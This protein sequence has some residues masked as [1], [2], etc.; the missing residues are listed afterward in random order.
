M[1]DRAG[2]YR[3][4]NGSAVSAAGRVLGLLVFVLA[5]GASAALVHSHVAARSVEAVAIVS[6]DAQL[7]AIYAAVD[8][9]SLDEALRLT[10]KLIA[11]QPNFRLA[12]LI[13]GD[14]LLAHV[15][16]LTGI[17]NVT[18]G[19]PERI[20]ELREEA[21]LRL[22]AYRNKPAANLVPRYLLELPPDQKTAVIIDTRR[23]RLYVYENVDGRP[24]FL[25]DYYVTQGKYGADKSKEGD[26]RTPVG[27]YHVTRLLP[28][29]EL[30]AFFGAGALPINYPNQWD[31]LN[32]RTGHGIWL[33]GTPPDTYARAPK[34]SDGCVVLANADWRALFHSIQIGVT[35]VI[36]S[37]DVEWLKQDD[38]NEERTSLQHAMESWRSDWESRDMNRYLSHYSNR[39]A[40][41]SEALRQWTARKSRVNAQ[42][43]W[44]KIEVRN[45]SMLR[46][47][48]KD[49][50]VVVTFDQS[51]RSNNMSNS[52]KK[53]QYWTHEGKNWK[54]LYE[55]AA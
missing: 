48:G 30:P 22:K 40:S 31:R 39:F 46:N 13:R 15:A 9:D 51:Y 24:R 47:P 17:G 37:D 44:V 5:Q 4:V 29:S 10:D 49:D 28:K 1:V 20:E 27:V 35:P 52:V 14:L 33:H 7:S 19:P 18:G 32:G 12:Y 11:E 3:S 25:A 2:A 50:L 16:P 53:V 23:S 8:R 55:G 36:I 34:D 21:L 41:D 6:P 54:I 38:W 45:V 26:M 43:D 42:K